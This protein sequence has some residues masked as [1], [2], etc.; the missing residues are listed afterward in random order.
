[1]G[2]GIGFSH[3]VSLG[4][5]ADVDFGDLLDFLALDPETRAILLYAENVTHARKF[6]SAGRIAAEVEKSIGHKSL[7]FLMFGFL[8]DLSVWVSLVVSR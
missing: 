3:L 7:P 6:M 8:I 5:M 4:D 1:M 2:H